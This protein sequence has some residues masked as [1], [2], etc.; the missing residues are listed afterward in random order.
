MVN[1]RAFLERLAAT[2]MTV[3]LT[4]SDFAHAYVTYLGL[5]VGQR[6]VRPRDAKVKCILEYAEPT[7]RKEF[8]RYGRL[9]QKVVKTLQTL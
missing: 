2:K 8:M 3:N 1:I 4:K 6:Q 5:I 7:T 9:F